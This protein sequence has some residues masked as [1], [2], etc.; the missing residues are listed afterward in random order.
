MPSGLHSIITWEGLSNPYSL[1]KSLG[2]T[3]VQEVCPAN[4]VRVIILLLLFNR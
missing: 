2:I 1:A 4:H 3:K